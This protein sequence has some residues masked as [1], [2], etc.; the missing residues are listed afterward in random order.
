MVVSN[1]GALP[2]KLEL[3]PKQGGGARPTGSAAPTATTKPDPKFEE[4]FE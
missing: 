2:P 3:K 4:K 1:D